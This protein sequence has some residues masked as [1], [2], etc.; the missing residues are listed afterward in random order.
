ML[1]L[2]ILKK[3][4][5][6]FRKRQKTGQWGLI[7]KGPNESNPELEFIMEVSLLKIEL[8]NRIRPVGSSLPSTHTK[9]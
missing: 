1:G 6:C 8:L 9:I 5:K 2:S 4:K 7:Y 3:F